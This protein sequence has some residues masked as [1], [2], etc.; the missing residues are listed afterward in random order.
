MTAIITQT[1]HFIFFSLSQQVELVDC[2]RANQSEAID[3]LE[4]A[5]VNLNQFW[6]AS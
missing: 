6:L 5:Q 2:L 3:P 1:A 4:R